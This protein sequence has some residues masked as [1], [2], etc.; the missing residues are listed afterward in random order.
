M[1]KKISSKSIGLYIS[2]FLCIAWMADNK[3]QILIN[4]QTPVNKVQLNPQIQ[5]PQPEFCKLG[6]NKDWLNPFIYV[7]LNGIYLTV[8]KCEVR[9]SIDVENLAQVLS[10]LP[11]SFW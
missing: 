4:A 5:R 6:N 1:K 7:G 11:L 9:Q 8:N 2:I 10:E 3:Q